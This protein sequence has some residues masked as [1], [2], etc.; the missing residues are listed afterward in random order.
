M[1]LSP[2][3]INQKEGVRILYMLKHISPIFKL[4]LQGDVCMPLLQMWKLSLKNITQ[5]P[6]CQ[7][8][9]TWKLSRSPLMVLQKSFLKDQQT[10]D[11]CLLL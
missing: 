6:V 2:S 9:R 1:D 11:Y 4:T 5:V 3:F 10:P 7:T 8:G